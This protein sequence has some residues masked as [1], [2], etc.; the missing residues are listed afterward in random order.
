M[1]ERKRLLLSEDY[2]IQALVPHVL[3]VEDWPS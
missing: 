1:N 2:N 3:M